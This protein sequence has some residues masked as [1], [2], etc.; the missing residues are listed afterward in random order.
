MLVPVLLHVCYLLYF[1]QLSKYMTIINMLRFT[2]LLVVSSVS[3]LLG[4]HIKVLSAR[5]CTFASVFNHEDVCL[6]HTI[7]GARV[8]LGCGSAYYLASQQMKAGPSSQ[9]AVGH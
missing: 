9:V 4:Y 3:L 6:V 2:F 8:C 1:N 7:T 5:R